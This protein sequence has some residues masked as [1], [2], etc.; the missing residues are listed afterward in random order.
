MKSLAEA[1]LKAAE[2]MFLWAHGWA[3][4]QEYGREFWIPP[5][6]YEWTNKVGVRH[7]RGHAINSLKSAI[8]NKRRLENM[9]KQADERRYE[10]PLDEDYY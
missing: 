10:D 9:A 8:G 4:V 5:G 2:S 7:R 6:D 1:L 3:T